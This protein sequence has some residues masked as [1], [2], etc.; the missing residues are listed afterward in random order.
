MY[1]KISLLILILLCSCA[2]AL[3]EDKVAKMQ[4]EISCNA[5]EMTSEETPDAD[6]LILETQKIMKKYGYNNSDL[7]SLKPVYEEEG[8]EDKVLEEMENMC[9]EFLK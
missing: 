5:L 1:V 8:F 7:E 9:P 2:P 3:E 6:A 4:A